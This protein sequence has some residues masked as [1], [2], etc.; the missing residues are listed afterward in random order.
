MSYINKHRTALVRTKLTDIGRELLAKGQL[1]FNSW[2]A[3]DSEVDYG[4]V[5]GWKDFVPGSSATTGQF[6]FHENSGDIEKNYS[7]ILRPKDKQYF[8]KT[9]LLTNNGDFIQPFAG[10][11]SLKLIKG[12]ISN[13]ADDRG[14][15]SG[16]TVDLGLSAV[17]TT[18]FYKEFGT[19]DLGKL[20]G[21]TDTT[22]FTK[23]VLRL[24]VALSS[25]S[26]DDI[27]VLN[28]SNSTLGD[29]TGTTNET[30][31]NITQFYMVTDVND[32]G[33]TINVD[34]A[35]P[36]MTAHSGTLVDFYVIPGGNDPADG[37]YGKPSLTSYWHTGTLAFD[38]SCDICLDN[39]PVWN[40]NN[41]WCEN[42]AGQYKDNVDFYHNHDL[43]GSEEYVGTKLLMNYKVTEEI[44]QALKEAA[45]SYMDPF[46]KGISIIHY[47]N[48]CI[49]NFYGEFFH[50]DG[51][52][53]KL[54][55]LDIPVMWHRRDDVGTASGTSVGM[56]FV[57]D[58]V[59]KTLTDTNIPYYDLLEYSGMSVTPE[60]PLA[61]GKVF[62]NEKI[63]VVDNEELLAA[64]SYKS[65]RNWTLPDLAMH[66]TNSVNGSCTGILKS[67]ERLYMTYYLSA[68]SGVTNTLPC[69][70]YAVIDNTTSSDK[71]IHFRL[72]N[73]SQLPYMRKVENPS[74]DGRGFF[75]NNMVVLA[76]V[77]DP[78]VTE[79]PDPMLWREIDFTTTN[80]T[81]NTGETIDPLLFEDQNPTQT[82]FILTGPT[83]TAAT[84]FNL[85]SYLDLPQGTY[86]E[87]MNFGDERL[88]YGNL[89][90]HIGA[91]VYKSLFSGNVR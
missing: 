9:F 54:L 71:D 14:F 4:Y 27:I 72:D 76:Q 20:S 21:E 51:D 2:I 34:R 23:G 8:P 33:S 38:S 17:T 15:F 69:Q 18:K 61:V 57:S 10:E 35:L 37:Y 65:N 5:K 80:I 25:T 82:G 43:F 11:S 31:P 16:S 89:R 70:R 12:V 30:T 6:F 63:V 42:M 26:V 22:T 74:Y 62:P 55:S 66:L 39:I 50:I 7:A 41:P 49:S 85:G 45:T 19:L 83:Y 28:L 68:D 60:S 53:G 64:M 75:A 58:T 36:N 24:D 32:S 77:V 47:T 56:R 13:Q 44:S 46:Q 87:K 1:T 91:T 90:T 29:V 59:E 73:I 67:G 52:S 88:F 3:G 81:T 79:R 40:M 84:T 78:T 86:Y 48:S